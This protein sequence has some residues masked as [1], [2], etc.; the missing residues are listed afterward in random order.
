MIEERDR[1]LR[2]EV[3]QQEVSRQ[4]EAAAAAS[5][6]QAAAART[7]ATGEFFRR[8]VV[9]ETVKANKRRYDRS[10]S[11]SRHMKLG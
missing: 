6:G 10:R 8:L 3:P 7:A 11:R 5:A 2:M 1:R 9:V 4:Q